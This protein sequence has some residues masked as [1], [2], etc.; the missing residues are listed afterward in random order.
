M[1]TSATRLTLGSYPWRIR[2]PPSRLRAT[3]MSLRKI[4]LLAS[5]LAV[6]ALVAAL[7]LPVAG[8]EGEAT[9]R[10]ESLPERVA[11][12]DVD[13]PERSL[14]RI[15]VPNLRG[16][17]SIGPQGRGG[18]AQRLP[19]RLALR[20]PRRALLRRR[21]RRRGP[22]HRARPVERGRR[23]GR[24]QGRDHRRG[25]SDSRADAPLRG[26]ARDLARALAHLPREPR[27]AAPV[28]APVRQRGAP[29]A[30]RPRGRVRHAASPS[31]DGAASGARTSWSRPSTA[32]A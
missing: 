10:E 9:S 1:I 17:A 21:P 8:Q 13:S 18:A 26:R 3:L 28:H 29:G 15:A 6:A 19:A 16:E 7:G 30:D 4:S 24:D 22:R 5:A 12:I 25:P 27:R 11:V 31:R 23:A 14:Y 20:R 2:P 32:T